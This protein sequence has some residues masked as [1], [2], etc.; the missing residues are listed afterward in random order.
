MS[1]PFKKAE[2]AEAIV[3]PHIMKTAGTSLIGWL[4]RH[5]YFEE[6][7]FAA[8]TWGELM[9]LPRS[10]F[11]GKRFVRGHFGS[12]I[13]RLFGPDKGFVPITLLRDPVDR[14]VSHFWHL[15]FAP[16]EHPFPFVREASFTIEEFVEHPMTRCVVSNYQTGNFSATLESEAKA[17]EDPVILEELSP[18]DFSVATAFIDS[19]AVVGVTEELPAFISA[20][21]QRFGFF[22][23]YQLPKHRSYRGETPVSDDVL[24]KIRALNE[25]DEELYRYVQKRSAAARTSLSVKVPQNPNRV[26]DD[27]NLQWV[28]GMPYWGRGWSDVMADERNKH[29]W[30]LERTAQLEFRVRRNECYALFF[31][32]LRFVTALQRD[33]FSVLCNGKEVEL[34]SLFARAGEDFEVYGFTLGPTESET[35]TVSFRVNSLFAFSQVSK[36]TNTLRRGLALANVTLVTCPA[37]DGADS[38]VP[39]QRPTDPSGS[40][41]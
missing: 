31:S 23:D 3:F 19:C 15:K 28:A 1:V 35:L 6:V 24:K 41:P 21:S 4:Q 25:I 11:K 8:T 12:G 17:G 20:I 29:I 36:D 18:V 30:S 9:R 10:A 26:G 5:Y 34:T 22:P 32:V 33:F 27:G 40:A 14:V 37:P 16:E 13:L 38:I 7:L 2:L 39:E